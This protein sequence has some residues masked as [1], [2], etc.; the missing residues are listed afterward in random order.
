MK[1]L[2]GKAVEGGDRGLFNV[3]LQ[4]YPKGTVGIQRG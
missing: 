1:V 4:H 2:I 3:L